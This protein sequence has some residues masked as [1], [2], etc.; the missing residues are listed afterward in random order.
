MAEWT[1]L[2][3]G[4]VASLEYGRPLRGYR[5]ANGD[6]PVFGTNGPVGTTTASL[7]DG[8]GV[9]V[10]RKGAY[11]GVH[12]AAG[13]FWVIDTA[14]FLRPT[15]PL[16]MRWAYYALKD[17]DLN[18]LDSGSA[19]PSTARADFYTVRVAFPP[20]GAQRAIGAL[21]GSVD[22]KIA[23]NERLLTAVDALCA[24]EYQRL[25]DS[26]ATVVG[27]GD[28]VELRYG[29]ALPRLDRVPGPIPVYGSSG[30]TGTHDQALASGPGIILGRKGT[31]GSVHWS[32]GDFFPI[33]TTFYLVPI[34][35]QI[36]LEYLYFALRNLRLDARNSDSAV[37]GLNRDDASRCPLRVPD[38]AR[39][40]RFAARVRPLFELAHRTRAESDRL[41]TLGAT[42]RPELI[43]G[44]VRVRDVDETLTP[45][46]E[47]VHDAAPEEG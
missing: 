11:R 23:A 5:G 26:A 9:I 22:D 40:A 42:L 8:P 29:K 32:R 13:A 18:S 6:V 38:S 28:L 41:A 15:R 35:E 1:R 36:P 34:T 17:T 10:G 14:Y 39:L 30:V 20:V 12:Y 7:D 46:G 43:A 19:I 24:A 37:P 4:Q 16:D 27:L 21:L 45:P 3:W 33:D 31:V 47:E 25:A 2:S 44:R